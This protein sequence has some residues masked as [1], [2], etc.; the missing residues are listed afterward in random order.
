MEFFLIVC[1]ELLVSDTCS[2]AQFTILLL[3]P[4]A[5]GTVYTCILFQALLIEI[6]FFDSQLKQKITIGDLV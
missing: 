6:F 5:A 3:N 4:C 1:E 2:S